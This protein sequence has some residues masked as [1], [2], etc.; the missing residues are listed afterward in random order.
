MCKKAFFLFLFFCAF[1]LQALH[2]VR[3]EFIFEKAPF[4]SCH[5]ST[6]TE[7]ADGTLL[8]AWFGGTAEG[9]N[10][11]AIWLS[12]CK[13]A[14]WSSVREVA[15]LPQVPCWNPVLFTLPSHEILLF[16]KGGRTPQTWSGFLKR[17][18]DSGHTWSSPEDL[19]AGVLGPIKN[20]PLLLDNGTLLC[21]SSVESY[22]RWGCWVEITPDGG[23]TWRK[24]NPINV[25]GQLFGIIQPTLFFGEDG[26]L[27]MLVRSHQ[28]GKVCV[29][30]S[31]DDG[32]TWTSA[33]ATSLPNPNAGI[34]AVNLQ[35][36]RILLVYNH[37]REGRSPLNVAIS[38]DGGKTWEKS[39][40]LENAPGEYSY[41]S[42][43]QTSDGQVHITYTWQ[44]EKIKHVVLRL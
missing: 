36:G 21:G 31:C 13:E 35:D 8:C 16:Y 33:V 43:I 37:C 40:V 19:P 24:S 6:I 44:R 20:K 5:A 1:T 4:A 17:S 25:E 38:S 27:R 9:E 32:N 34:D 26:N 29:A 11:V 41:P 2:V 23:R 10:D 18:F 30:S 22:K 42:V 7:T 39:L 12:E 14:K 28:V 15:R 3:E